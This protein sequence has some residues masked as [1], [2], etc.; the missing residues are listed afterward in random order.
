MLIVSKLTFERRYLSCVFFYSCKNIVI[1]QMGERVLSSLQHV[2][3]VMSSDI[4]KNRD[5]GLP[6]YNKYRKLCG[7]PVAKSFDDLRMWMHD[8]VRA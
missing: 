8:E 6:S 4:Q 5:V 3:D 2:S 1:P 7:L